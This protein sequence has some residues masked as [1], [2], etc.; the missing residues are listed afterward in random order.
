M[1]LDGRTQC[2]RWKGK[3]AQD[4]AEFGEAVHSKLN[5]KCKAKVSQRSWVSRVSLEE[6][7][8]RFRTED[9]QAESTPKTF[10]QKGRIHR[11]ALRDENFL[12]H[13]WSEQSAGCQ[14]LIRGTRREHSDKDGACVQ[15]VIA[16]PHAGQ[17]RIQFQTE[18]YNPNLASGIL[19]PCDQ[20]VRGWGQLGTR[21]EALG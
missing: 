8:L 3:K 19:A 16:A 6:L 15:R 18:K 1:S 9:A 4:T 2:A 21:P 12:E 10:G 14:S 17:R 5:I 13:R 7:R 11:L 20:E